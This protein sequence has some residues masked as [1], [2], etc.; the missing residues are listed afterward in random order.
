MRHIHLTIAPGLVAAVIVPHAVIAQATEST[1]STSAVAEVIVT[2]QRRQER[3]LNVPI[4]IVSK[5][6]DQL[7]SA[8]VRRSFDLAQVVPGLR[9]DEDG[10]FV[11]PTLRGIGNAIAGAGVN[12]GVAT[13]T[14]GYYQPSEQGNNFDLVGIDSIQVLK[15]PQGTLFGRNATGGAISVTTLKP[16]FVPH[17]QALVDYGRFN[18]WRTQLYASTGITNTIAVNVAG[19]YH[20]SDGFSKNIFTG[21]NSGTIDKWSVRGKVLWQPNKEFSAIL[22]YERSHTE[23][24]SAVAYDSFDGLNNA[25]FFVKLLGLPVPPGGVLAPSTRGQTA[26][27]SP[28][29]FFGWDEK[30]YLTLTEQI[31]NFATLTSY[32]GYQRERYAYQ[33]DFDASNV[34]LLTALGPQTEETFTQEFNLASNTPGRLQWVGGL[35]YY[36]DHSIAS[37]YL[38]QG[39][40]VAGPG[41]PVNFF[42]A[43][44]ISKAY[45]IFGDVT[46][47][48]MD[49]L[50]IT[51]GA[52]GSLEDQIGL[53]QQTPP[54]GTPERATQSFSAF[55]P[56]GVLRY[57]FMPDANVFFSYS[58]GFKAGG[59]STTD[60]SELP[61]IP[62]FKP[63]TVDAY[64]VGLKL[65][66]GR[67]RLE[68]S[69]YYNKYKDQQVAYYTSGVGHISNAASA[70]IYGAELS[71]TDRVTDGLTLGLNGAWMHGRYTSFPN[72]TES[73]LSGQVTVDVSGQPMARVPE[74]T[75]TLFA[76]YEQPFAGG[77]IA[78]NGSYYLTSRYRFD[79]A[80]AYQQSGYGLLNAR[81]TYTLPDGHTSVSAFGDNITD[82]KY[83]ASVLPFV[84]VAILQQWA[85]PA[86][87]GIEL[88]YKY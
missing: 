81:V 69:V 75:G 9:I 79:P 82:T 74:W 58:R 25:A 28:N 39:Y 49:K 51:L 23:D 85:T 55:T 88:A 68:S 13:Y 61:K 59:F 10:P 14:D 41:V 83:T 46:Y 42:Y 63:E 16:T 15:G 84:P 44:Q 52:R 30:T 43:G 70:N 21:Q 20:H 6:G 47:R 34:P 32:T 45:A 26:A 3:S 73:L 54:Y 24:D 87:W 53:A 17:V 60:F 18:D 40:L 1:Q 48:V 33:I 2:A 36:W 62:S 7:V 37:P 57:N 19:N 12:P 38:G 35:F 8:G 71:L 86:T 31:A 66:H 4:S 72:A 65:S 80:G 76:N 5:T 77:K 11:Q 67:I 50:F 64:E 56:R 27:D 29:H 78:L 22:S